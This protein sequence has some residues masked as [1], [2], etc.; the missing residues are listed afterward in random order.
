MHHFWLPSLSCLPH[1]PTGIFLYH[2]P[3]KL[4][5]FK[6]SFPDLLLEASKLRHLPLLI[7]GP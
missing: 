5:G 6:S 4:P 2:L 7:S 1:S 3:N